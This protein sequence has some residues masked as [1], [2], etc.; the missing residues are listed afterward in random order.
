MALFLVAEGG[1]ET[2]VVGLREDY[3]V[4]YTCLRDGRVGRVVRVV[5]I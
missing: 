1:R 4:I 3:W 5:R 2:G